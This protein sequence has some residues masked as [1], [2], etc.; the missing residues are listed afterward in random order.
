M[1][2]ELLE[3]IETKTNELEIKHGIKENTIDLNQSYEYVKY[4]Y[5]NEEK[6]ID[7]D[8]SLKDETKINKKKIFIII[9]IVLLIIIIVG[10]L[11]YKKIIKF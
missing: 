5:D 7:T 2:N 3:E 10:I 9:G 1:S 6:N 4:D 11:I 8:D